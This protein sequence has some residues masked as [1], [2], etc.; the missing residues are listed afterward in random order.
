MRPLRTHQAATVDPDLTH[1]SW[2]LAD[3]RHGLRATMWVV[4][5]NGTPTPDLDT[6]LA[7]TGKIGDH[8]ATR[9]K[10]KDLDGKTKVRAWGPSSDRT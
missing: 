2:L 4:E 3:G 7:V 5:V 9:L 1:V 8:V 10:T 6:F